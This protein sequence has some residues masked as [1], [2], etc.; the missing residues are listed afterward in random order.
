[1]KAIT[2]LKTNKSAG[3]D[4]LINEFFIHGKHILASTLVNLFNKI[5]EVGHFPEAWSEG[6]VI[7]LHKKGS[8]NDAENYRGI[9]LLS[10][11][12]KLFTRV[13]N[14]RL[15]E[16]AENYGVLIEAQA[17]FRAGMSTTDNIFV[18]HGL[19]THMLNNDNQLFCA[20]ID[21]T[22]AFD[23]IV[24]E[25]LWYKLVNL[26]L[27]GNIL[28]IMK[29]MYSSVKSRVKFSNK[30]G[31]EFQCSLGVRQG[32]CLSP[33]LFSF[34]LNDI[35]EQFINSGLDGIDTDML[36][37]FML[38]YA[39][40]IV[41]FANTKEQLQ[42]SLDLLLEYCNRWK[43]TINISKTKVIVFRNGGVL[44]QEMNFYYNGEVLEIVSEFTYLGI[45]F[46]PGGSF[47]GTQS[48]LAGQAQKAIFK[49]NKYLHKFTYISPKHKLDLFDKLVTPILNYS[50]E[51]WGF[52]QAKAIERV[53]LSFC[54]NILGVKKNAQNDFIYGE[55]GRTAYQTK[56]YF[57]IIKYWFK[58]VTA[59][60][61][62]YIRII[63]ELMLRDIENLPTKVNWASLV[64][65]LFM[66]LGYY[67]VWVNQGVGDYDIFMRSIK[68]R[69][70]D[71][72]VQNWH[73]RLEES[74]RAVFYRSI[75]S[76]Q[77]Q[78][79]LNVLN[80]TK[81]SHA[82]S[83]LRV[84]SHRLQIE[85]GRWVRPR[86]IPVNERKCTICQV[87]EDEFHFLIEC[88]LYTELRRKYIP[89]YY[90]RRPSMLKLVELINT[91]NSRLLKKL[92]S[93]IYHAFKTRNEHLY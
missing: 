14:N 21:F 63:Y 6:Y 87:V 81:I 85:A 36:K 88:P 51:V 9:T 59:R 83:K 18:L 60:N 65:N 72:F 52:G 45:V 28:N 27:R 38:L 44:P 7:P 41:I 62:K 33:L 57:I 39:D 89:N 55:L 53:H 58:I 25:N 64:K 15:G 68:Q 40:D 54:K 46:T 80:V 35:E 29:S 42:N 11:I 56:R 20:F 91:H 16:W 50:C 71:N 92:G 84:S 69:L 70:N 4:M 19:I 5:F 3:P 37:I 1:M 67:E 17:G 86:R 61:D 8:V 48:T 79:Y 13:L 43:L 34:Y 77:F 22:K 73:S 31:N 47:S 24:R 49:M 23:Y 10:T 30:L 90:Y 66:T 75:A 12:G 26:G 76:F 82:L 78:P 93:F 32:E 74:S 2:Q